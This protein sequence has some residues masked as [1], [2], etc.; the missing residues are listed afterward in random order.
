ML[1]LRLKQIKGILEEKKQ[2]LNLEEEESDL[3]NE[4][5]SLDRELKNQLRE[6]RTSKLRLVEMI[7]PSPDKCPACGRRF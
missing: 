2:N 5:I 4:L 6:R 7:A 1:P 3:L